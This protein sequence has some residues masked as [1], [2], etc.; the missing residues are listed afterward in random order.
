MSGKYTVPAE[1]RAMKPEGI[2]STV[3]Q[4]GGH[5]Y[6][7]EHLRVR[8]PETRKMKNASGKCLGKITLEDGFIPSNKSIMKDDIS[9]LDCGQYLIGFKNSKDVLDLLM[10]FF[11]QDEAK[12]IY[13]LGL[14]Y[15]A[16]GF[17]KIRDALD[18]YESSILKLL[19][20]NLHLSENSLS[21]FLKAL[22]QR[23]KRLESFEQALINKGSGYY[24]LDGHVILSTSTQNDLAAYGNKYSKIGNTQQNLMCIFDVELNRP[25]SCKAF[26]G[27][28]LDMTYVEELFDIYSFH[29]TVFIADAGFYSPRAINL[30]VANGN[31]YVMPLPAKY[32]D[33][34]NAVKEI[35]FEGE[36]TYS[37]G[38][39]KK[40]HKS[41]I[42]YKELAKNSLNGNRLIMFRDEEMNMKLRAEYRASIGTDDTHTEEKYLKYKDTFGLIILETNMEDAP[43]AIYST[44]KKRW[45]IETYYNHVK[46]FEQF[47]AL[48]DKDYYV[49]Q[50]ESF[51]LAIEG[52]IY[53]AFM[54]ALQSSKEKVLANKSQNECISI[55]ARLKLSQHADKRWHKNQ[56]RDTVMKLLV[57]LN[58][59]LEADL[60]T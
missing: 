24:A 3:K 50:S 45:K 42:S 39:G 38:N 34:K 12:T 31:K 4:I 36:F 22:G 18:V 25:I 51:I 1:I 43:E 13:C 52:L 60:P 27:G 58:V 53:S 59:D 56:L 30:F 48:H 19:F 5:Y 46:N 23:P 20:K 33:F 6:V 7:Y 9:I 29:N 14:M 2:S 15:F 21:K 37:K 54:R 57:A 17:T 49:A 55:A 16:N 32:K 8:D 40:A 26:D 47:K 28:T 35:S 11:N 10:K 44:Y 41:L